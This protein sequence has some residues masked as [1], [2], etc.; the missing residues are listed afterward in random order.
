MTGEGCGPK[1][2]GKRKGVSSGGP[3]LG[4]QDRKN[5]T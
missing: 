2:K 5:G 3:T 4:K 1:G